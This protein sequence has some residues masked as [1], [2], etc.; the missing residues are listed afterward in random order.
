MSNA[1][2]TISVIIP[3]YNA[4]STL[5]ACLESLKNQTYAKW[6]AVCVNDGSSDSTL[7]LLNN[8][9]QSDARIKVLSQQNAG[10]SAAR[11][12]ALDAATGDVAMFMDCDDWYEPNAC[13]NV[14]EA[15][16]DPEVDIMAFG[17]TCVPE[18]AA[19][20]HVRDLLSPSNEMLQGFN[21]EV[22]FRKNAQPYIARIA[23]RRDFLNS[24]NLRFA[25]N[26]RLAEDTAFLFEAYPFARKTV[27]SQAKLYNYRMNADSITHELNASD[28]AK[29]KL[30]QHLAAIQHI[31]ETWKAHGAL[32]LCD[33]QMVSWCLDFTLFDINRLEPTDQTAYI[34]KLDAILASAYPTYQT[35][36]LK[37]PVKKAARYV[38]SHNARALF[39]GPA[40]KAD[41]IRFFI[42][43]RGL[44]Q[45]IERFI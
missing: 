29:A 39:E 27:L 16:E 6:E 36:P 1:Q 37:A 38:A 35:L 20:K 8:F 34:E 28:A 7:A 13:Q 9:A 12:T 45:C 10:P 15:F 26:I 30:D 17:A 40:A 41:F 18:T 21:P 19:P 3:V 43:T 4:E 14:A 23:A 24:R 42:A 25:T 2:P 32:H 5:S 22:L 44:K 33:A 31:L 11:N